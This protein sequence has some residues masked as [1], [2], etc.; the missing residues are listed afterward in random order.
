MH[1]T[2]TST[3]KLT[4]GQT[5]GTVTVTAT[6][7]DNTAV[8]A[9]MIVTIY[10]P[11]VQLT[12]YVVDLS[13]GNASFNE[14]D[15]AIVT[16]AM[17]GEELHMTYTGNNARYFIDLGEAVDMASYDKIEITAEMPYKMVFDLWDLS[18]DRNAYPEGTTVSWWDLS[19]SASS[20]Y[21]K[22]DAG[23]GTYDD[24][25]NL[26]TLTTSINIP[27]AGVSSIKN[28]SFSSNDSRFV[29]ANTVIKIK[30]TKFK[31]PEVVDPN[32]PAKKDVLD[33]LVVEYPLEEIGRAH[34]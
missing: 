29:D 5:A 22:G 21:D 25:G 9:S 24:G 10:Q 33:D 3:G 11:E 23:V 27:K 2:I 7:K 30:S 14:W 32:E 28:I 31:V 4:V 17:V 26:T 1:A 13:K 6:A 16:G 15:K 34:V 18:F 19:K 20:P 8:K 12:D